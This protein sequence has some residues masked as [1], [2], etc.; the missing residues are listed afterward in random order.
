MYTPTDPEA[1]DLE[2]VM[3][4]AQSADGPAELLRVWEQAHQGFLRRGAVEAAAR[5]AIWLGMALFDRAEYARGGGWIARARRL[6]EDGQRDCV[7]Q[8]YLLLPVA[9][10]AIAAGRL[11][12]GIAF[13]DRGIEVGK[14]FNDQDL[15]IMSRHGQGRVRIRAGQCAEGL[16]LLDEVMAAVTSGEASSLVTGI[17]Y[18]SVIDACAE[19]FDSRQS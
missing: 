9:M 1:L 17:V 7:E 19:I 8:G 15:V 13:S 4:A 6:L 11:E 3:E 16:A 2:Q 18:C 10:Q 5:C 12:D 14:R